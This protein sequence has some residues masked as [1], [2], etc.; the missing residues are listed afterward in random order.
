MLNYSAN[1]PANQT[2]S[3]VSAVRPKNALSVKLLKLF[4]F[5]SLTVS[6]TEHVTATTSDPSQCTQWRM[7]WSG[8]TK[9]ES[10]TAWTVA[11]SS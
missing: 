11:E 9:I 7:G 6:K 1:E 5:S 8:R 3:D 10:P 2:H 4:P